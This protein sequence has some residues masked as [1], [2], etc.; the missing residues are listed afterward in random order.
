M[1]ILKA[2]TDWRFIND[3]LPLESPYLVDLLALWRSKMRDGKIPSRSDFQAE[4]FMQFGGRIVLIDVERQPLR[5]KYRLIGSHITNVL[6][7]DSTGKYLDEIYDSD[8]YTKA[9]ETYKRNID[10]KIPFRAHGEMVHAFKP[11]LSFEAVDIPLSSDGESVDMIL[12][13]ADFR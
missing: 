7:R 9:V 2:Y 5:F 8:F 13:G 3:D 11:Y 4:E 6:D 1:R 12:K 10:E